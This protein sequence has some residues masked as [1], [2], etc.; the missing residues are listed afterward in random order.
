MELEHGTTAHKK[1]WSRGLAIWISHRFIILYLGAIVAAN[2]ITAWQGAWVTP[3]NAF[4]LIGL[5]ITSR[6]SLHDSWQ[7]RGL[8]WKMATLIASGSLLSWLLNR[9][10]G[11]VAVASFVA[12]AGSGAIDALV[13]SLFGKKDQLVRVNASNFASAAVDSIVFSAIAF[14]W[15]PILS[16]VYGQFTAKVA[17]GLLWSLLL[18]RRKINESCA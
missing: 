6:D 12:F 10:A 7:N 14:G 9:N 4:L 5:N 11:R 13:Y 16:I 18:K 2:L 1:L 17:G 8:W 3:I 15:L